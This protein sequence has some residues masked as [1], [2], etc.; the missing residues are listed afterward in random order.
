MNTKSESTQEH[1]KFDTEVGK[2]LQL[3]IHSLYANKDIFLRELISNSSDACDKLRYLSI[4]NPELTKDDSQFKIRITADEAKRTLTI[5]DNGIG[6]NREDLIENI[7]TIA[8]SGTQNFAS[9]LTGDN[10]KDLQLIGQFGVGFYSAFMVADK[11]EVMSCKAGEKNAWLWQSKGDGEYIIEKLSQCDLTRGTSVILHL[12]PEEDIFLDKF[13]IRHVIKTYSDHIAFP[14]EFTPSEG[15]TEVLNNASAI[16][17]RPKN[18]ITPEQHNEFYKQVSHLPDSP[19][20]IIHNKNEG[21]VEF[22][23]LLYIPASKPFDLF[24]PDRRSKLKLYIKR[25]FIGSEGIDLAPSYLRFLHGVIDSEDLPLNINRETLQHS[26]SLEKIRK[27][28]TK[29]VISE[30]NSKMNKDRENYLSFW[31]NFGAVLKEGLCEALVADEREKLLEVCLFKSALHNKL[32]SLAEYIA[33]MKDGQNTIFYLSADDPEKAQNS[34]QLEGFIKRD[35]DVLLFTDTVDDFW[36]SVIHN[37]K[38]KELKSV[39]RSGIELDSILKAN[40]SEEENSKEPEVLSDNDQ[41]LIDYFKKVLG[42]LVMDVKISKKLVDSP[43]CLTVAEGAMD[44]RM[45]R[46]L[47]DQKQLHTSFAKI[48]EINSNHSI[49]SKITQEIHKGDTL[50]DELILALFD[51]SCIMEGEPIKDMHA[52]A[53]RMNNLLGRI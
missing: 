41:K 33:N 37:F 47:K 3:M 20:D 24:N 21:M 46:Y 53:K 42:G 4:T 27:A 5:T 7:G 2:I 19:W 52:F 18:E 29:K 11:I 44:I 13:R 40:N 35:I 15:E 1:I 48:L 16:W 45:E 49:I 22:T 12:K 28:L 14:I 6:M 39:T 38:D 43:V 31:N 9:K 8:R 30:L 26:H 25:V 34:P 10:S 32:I 23:N 36:V 17:M 51:Q 50:A